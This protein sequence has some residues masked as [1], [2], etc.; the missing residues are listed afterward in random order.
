M[1]LAKATAGFIAGFFNNENKIDIYTSSYQF[2]LIVFF[3][4]LANNLIYFGIYFQGTVLSFPQLLLRYVLPTAIYT[5]VIATL[6]LVMMKRRPAI[7]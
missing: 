4:S 7:G 3:C 6:P 2:L 1:A 5:A